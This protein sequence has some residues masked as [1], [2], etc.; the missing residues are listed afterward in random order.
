[1]MAARSRAFFD[2][3]SALPQTTEVPVPPSVRVT[4]FGVVADIAVTCARMSLGS[5]RNTVPIASNAGDPIPPVTV[6][7]GC[8]AGASAVVERATPAAS[9]SVKPAADSTDPIGVRSTTRTT[10]SCGGR[11][12]SV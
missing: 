9:T 1:M 5:E 8:P 2:E 10:S 4:S 11:A 3:S 12:S 6:M 7:T